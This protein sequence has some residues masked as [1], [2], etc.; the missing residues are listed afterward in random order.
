MLGY[1][2][3]ARPI[4]RVSDYD[5]MRSRPDCRARFACTFDYLLSLIVVELVRPSSVVVVVVVF[6]VVCVSLCTVDPR[7]AAPAPYD[8]SFCIYDIPP[9]PLGARRSR[10]FWNRGLAQSGSVSGRYDYKSWLA[11]WLHGQLAGSYL[12]HRAAR[13]PGR[14]AGAD[15]GRESW[16]W[17]WLMALRSSAWTVMM[18]EN[19]PWRWLGS[20]CRP[21]G[22]VCLRSFR[23]TRGESSSDQM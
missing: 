15:D 5:S 13:R 23:S 6:V 7:P 19:R 12:S 8:L 20:A 18:G 16:P 21:A 22:R 17:R 2:A 11:G 4:F 1:F 9:R 10:I 14:P 3:V